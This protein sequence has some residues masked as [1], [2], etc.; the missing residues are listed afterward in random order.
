MQE[1]T[2][3]T[4]NV[5]VANDKAAYD[6]ACKALLSEKIILAWIMKSCVE[7]YRDMDVK[8]IAD[9]CIEGEP[10]VGSSAVLP[11]AENSPM[12]EGSNTEDSTMNEGTIR[13][14]IRFNAIIPHSEK[15]IRL[16]EGIAL[17][18]VTKSQRKT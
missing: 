5:E 15:R 8:E 10:E 18:V 6:T 16:K 17:L 12:I 13:Y 9:I 3:L 7:E 11:D 4:K 14:D 1:K 2:T